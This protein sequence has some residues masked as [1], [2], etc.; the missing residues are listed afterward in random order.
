MVDLE[1]N[2]LSEAFTLWPDLPDA[3]VS[4]LLSFDLTKGIKDEKQIVWLGEDEAALVVFE[5]AQL[6]DRRLLITTESCDLPDE[7]HLL[8]APE[9]KVSGVR[10]SEEL[11]TVWA[12]VDKFDTFADL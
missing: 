11:L 8:N 4:L 5:A 12:K 3:L 9:C 2:Q 1:I 10:D 7:L 6:C